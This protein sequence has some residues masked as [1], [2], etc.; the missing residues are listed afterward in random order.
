MSTSEVF[1][2]FYAK[3]VKTLPMDDTLFIADLFSEGLL[4]GNLK[5]QIQ[6][7]STSADKAMHFLDNGIK[8]GLTSDVGSFNKLLNVMKGSEYGEVK[9][10]AQKISA[11]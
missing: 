9:E 11:G 2:Q 4:P 3:L 10:L 5:D 6:K 8:P 7:K 1:Q